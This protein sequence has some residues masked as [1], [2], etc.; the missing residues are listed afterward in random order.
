MAS[1]LLSVGLNY[2]KGGS[3]VQKTNHIYFA[4]RT[5]REFSQ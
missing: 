4:Q 5:N 3:I 1:L 2:F